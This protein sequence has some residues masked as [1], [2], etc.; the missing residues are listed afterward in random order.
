MIDIYGFV[1][2]W[3]Y[4]DAA[5]TAPQEVLS[6]MDRHGIDSLAIC[7]TRSI[8]YDWRQ[9]NEETIALAEQYPERFFAFISLSPILP[10]PELIRYL[11]DGKKRNI[12]GIR[13][14][15]QHQNYSLTG[16]SGTNTILEAAQALDLPVV[17]A[18]RVVMDWGL[19]E[20]DTSTIET[21]VSRYPKLRFILTGISDEDTLW[22]Y[23]FMKR[24][25]N[26]YL[27]ISALQGF[28]A[29]DAAVAV[30]GADKVLFGTGLPILYPACSI[31][32]LNNLKV[33]PEAKLAVSENNARLLLN[34]PEKL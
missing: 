24:F 34:S 33:S 21:V 28:R 4:W 16:L 15:P 17:L 10:A 3:P 11:E 27:E 20:L 32:K 31:E 22:V 29:V 9:G 12:K 7:S 1:G 14:Y 30:V 25:P 18:L 23:D 6:L 8:F 13:L 2:P 26:V 19:P 5:Y